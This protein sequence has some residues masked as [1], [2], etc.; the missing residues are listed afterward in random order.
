MWADVAL[1]LGAYLL[2]SLP[3]LSALGKARGIA[4][5]GDLH[6]SLW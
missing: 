1:I 3:Y 2:G 5:E 6:I 4:L